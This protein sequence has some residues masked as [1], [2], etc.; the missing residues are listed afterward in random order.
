M[1]ITVVVQRH[2]DECGRCSL[3]RLCRRADPRLKAAA[4]ELERQRATMAMQGRST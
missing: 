2:E 3:E 4:D 1:L